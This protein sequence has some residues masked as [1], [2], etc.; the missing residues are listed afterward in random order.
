MATNQHSPQSVRRAPSAGLLRPFH[1]IEVSNAN[2]PT[3][4]LRRVGCSN[5]K[6]RATDCS[7]TSAGDCVATQRCTRKHPLPL[8]VAD[9]ELYLTNSFAVRMGTGADY[10]PGLKGYT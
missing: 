10:A 2:N 3:G 4:I 1:N 8:Y 6:R 9:I 5:A 7:M